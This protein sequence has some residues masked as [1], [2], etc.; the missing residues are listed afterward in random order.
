[1]VGD[2]EK[3]KLITRKDLLDRLDYYYYDESIIPERT[4]KPAYNYKISKDKVP[5]ALRKYRDK[6][7]AN[8]EKMVAGLTDLELLDLLE[9]VI[10]EYTFELY[11]DQIDGG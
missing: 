11:K 5:E 9:G 10:Q 2:L 7:R 3:N 6:L 8:Y 1:M 4:P